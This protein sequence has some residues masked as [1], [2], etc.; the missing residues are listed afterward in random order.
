MVPA[1]KQLDLKAAIAY[2]LSSKWT[3]LPSLRFLGAEY[4]NEMVKIYG[5][6][7]FT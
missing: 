1:E 4:I 2:R 6:T 3:I 7:R 5:L